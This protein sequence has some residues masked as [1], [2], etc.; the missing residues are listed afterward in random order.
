MKSRVVTGFT[1]MIMKLSPTLP[2]LFALYLAACTTADKSIK[3]KPSVTINRTGH[4][5]V[6]AGL[7]ESLAPSPEFETFLVSNGDRSFHSSLAFYET[8]LSYGPLAD[9]RPIFLLTNSYIVNRQQAQGIDFMEKIFGQYG[10]TMKPE[11]KSTYL[12]AYALLRATN[13]DEVPLFKR[14][15]W[16]NKT[17]EILEEANQLFEN[18]PLV[19]WSAGIIYA[20]V[21]W[22]FDKK[23]KA[24]KELEWLVERPELEPTPGFYREAYHYLAKLYSDEGNES[25]TNQYLQKSGYTDYEPKSLFMGWFSTTRE[26]GL[27]FSPTPQ[28]EEIVADRVF[29]LRGFGF[30]D[31]HFVISANGQELISIDAGTQPYSFQAGYEYFK[32]YRPDAPELTTVL[33]THSHWDHIGGH[34]YLKELNP[35]IKFYGRDNYRGTLERAQRNHVYHQI[36]GENFNNEWF[37]QYKPD[38]PVSARQEIV[39]GNSSIE[40]IPVTGGETEDALLIDFHDL[41]VL[42]MGD[43][44]MPFY[45]E[46]WVEE[47]FIEEAMATMDTAL[48]LNPKQILHGHV[49]IN[50]LYGQPQQLKVYRGAFEWLVKETNK[51]VVNGYSVKEIIRLNLIPPGLQNNPEAFFGYVAAR[52][53]VISRVVDKMVGIW[54]ENS[55]GQ[56][57]AGLDVITAVEY[58]RMLDLYL[59]LSVGEVEKMLR[60]TLDNGDNELALQMAVA[61]EIRY[62]KNQKIKLLKEE[63]ADR[64]RSDVQFFDPFKFAT[65]TEIIHQ[66][67]KEILID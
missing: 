21:P 36:R 49:G 24:I 5:V 44:L 33:I 56:E 2:L 9:P 30:S 28:I 4:R 20:Q 39:I 67:H 29:A 66:E 63:A 52:D 65:Y 47:G 8:V 14:I 59:G 15:G 46:P 48:A 53:Q 38:H 37:A 41:G 25:L 7:S 17:F 6:T 10:E 57:P 42:F 51:H 62:T 13:A 31:L 11:V 60:K 19:H 55:S 27:L 1:I 3:F 16:V 34:T 58:G 43:A 22:F 40:L 61:A 35:D 64:L 23:A 50:I 18:N 45:G 26:K 32:A 54:G 12:A